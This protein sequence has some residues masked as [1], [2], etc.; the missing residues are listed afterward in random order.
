MSGA[1][2]GNDLAYSNFAAIREFL[3]LQFLRSYYKEA[4]N[5][6]IPS[7]SFPSLPL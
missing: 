3:L 1:G 6:K 4:G 2:R 5:M 7:V